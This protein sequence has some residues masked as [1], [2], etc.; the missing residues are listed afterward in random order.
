[1]KISFGSWA[2]SFGPFADN[3]IPFEKTVKRL[4]S[5]GYDGIEICGFPPHVTHDREAQQKPGAQL[6][7]SEH[8]SFGFGFFTLQPPRTPASGQSLPNEPLGQ[9]AVS[10][11]QDGG[12]GVRAQPPFMHF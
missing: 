11:W 7:L 1:M 8:C 3:P 6:P 12:L 2:F 4:S 5:A 9:P 10:G